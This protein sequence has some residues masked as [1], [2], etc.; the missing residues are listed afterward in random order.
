MLD[1]D[2]HIRQ[3]LKA[4]DPAALTAYRAVKAKINLKL[5]EAGRGH[6][7]PLSEPELLAL[8]QREIK[9]RTESN[10]FLTPERADYRENARIIAVLS[11]HLPKALSGAELDA[12]VRKAI[13]EA[14]AAG[15]KDLGK[16]MAALRQVPGVDMASAS[17]RVMN[18]RS[19]AERTLMR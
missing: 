10:E 19:A 2:A 13:A 11:A 16:V 6:D 12:A 9:E 5:T 4:K 8:V 17:A 7:K 15:P 18:W 14:G 1:I 3:S